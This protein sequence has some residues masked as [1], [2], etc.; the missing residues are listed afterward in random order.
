MSAPAG[1]APPVDQP[2]P[3]P[4]V[5]RHGGFWVRFAA[6]VVDSFIIGVGIA[7]ILVPL[8]ILLAVTNAEGVGLLV[9]WTI[10]L[11]LPQLYHA[12]FLSSARMATPGKRLCGLYVTDTEGHRLTFGRA[13]WRNVAALFSYITFYIGFIMAGL[14]ERKR[15][16]HDL[17]AGT[18]VH[19]QPG[20]SVVILIGVAAAAFAIVAVIGI[21]AAVAIP[22]HL[23]FQRRS[24]L[25]SIYGAISSLKTPIADYVE[26]KK[27]WPESLEQLGVP[28]PAAQLGA[29]ERAI[30][31]EIR[32][33]KEGE[34]TA[35]V[36]L[37]DLSLS[38]QIRLTPR[39]S[40]NEFEWTCTASK[41]IWKYITATCRT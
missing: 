29:K 3:P 40:G 36:K 20:G 23:D 9:V 5:P 34:V 26:Q 10:V 25:A 32:L 31:Q 27:A 22:A 13:F 41:E 37:A 14:N 1:Y 21:L 4:P 24:H 7:V 18:V 38:G 33:G 8:V 6:Y 35:A 2:P 19:R 30:V 17:L 15:A 39:R 16:L 11:L 12:Y 28:D